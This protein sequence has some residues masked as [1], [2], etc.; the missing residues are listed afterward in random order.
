MVSLTGLR[1]FAVLVLGLTL[2]CGRGE[3]QAGPPATREATTPNDAAHRNLTGPHG[4]HS[5]HHDGLVLMNGD[6][7]Y[8]VVLAKDGRHQ[9]WFSDAV[10]S[11]LPASVAR[12]V[13]LEVVRPAAP[14]EVV[15]LRIDDA[16]ESW[17]AGA[18][19]VEGD[20]VI[21]KLRYALQGEPHEI[22]VPFLAPP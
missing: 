1:T 21:V 14:V 9:I 16:G 7:H 12:D 5:P 15:T 13:T 20:G 17:I 22:D 2:G 3:P 10:R 6:V 18:Q 19:P 8:E 4:D 11:E